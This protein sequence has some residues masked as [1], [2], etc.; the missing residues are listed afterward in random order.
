MILRPYQ[1]DAI[2]SI[3]DYFEEGN[4]GNAVLALPTGTGKSVI[5]AG[6]I[7]RVLNMWPRQ[8][9]MVLTHVKELIEQDH[10][11]LKTIWPNAPTGIYSAGLN[12]KIQF[13][14][15]FLAVWLR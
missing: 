1:E 6:F 12:Q 15:L 13:N 11:K 10:E 5:L 2:Q 8:R 3:F 9:F 4:Q 7:Q 14:P